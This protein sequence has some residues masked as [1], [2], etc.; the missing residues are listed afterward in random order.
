MAVIVVAA[1]GS[2]LLRARLKVAISFCGCF[3]HFCVA[4]HRSRCC[5]FSSHCFI[6]I[7]HIDVPSMYIIQIKLIKSLSHGYSFKSK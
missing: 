1:S 2:G 5:V 7:L 3:D 4:R 6:C